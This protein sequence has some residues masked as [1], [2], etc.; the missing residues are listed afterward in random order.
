MMPVHGPPP[1]VPAPDHAPLMKFWS[2]TWVS[3]LRRLC[4]LPVCVSSC[5]TMRSL[6]SHLR[7]KTCLHAFCS[8]GESVAEGRRQSRP[9]L[10]RSAALAV[11]GSKLSGGAGLAK[12]PVKL[13]LIRG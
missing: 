13:V 2:F 9:C 5:G 1:R 4:V 6:A 12:A 11:L 7:E 8:A 3:G 10:T